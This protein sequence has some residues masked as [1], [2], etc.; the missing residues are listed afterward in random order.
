MDISKLRTRKEIPA[1]V[2]SLGL[3]DTWVEVGVQRGFYSRVLLEFC[4]ELK[5]LIL[6]DAWR[7]LGK[8]YRDTA[9]VSNAE[10]EKRLAICKRNLA[11]WD[12]A[13]KLEYLRMTS[14]DAAKTIEAESLDFVYLDADHSYRAVTD[15]IKAWFP[16]IKWGGVIAGHDYIDGQVNNSEFGVKRAVTEFAKSNRLEVYRTTQIE[17]FPSWII[18]KERRKCRRH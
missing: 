16:L 4:P 12:K 8:E 3:T 11:Y 9:N 10:H 6:V 18:R 15:D 7:N 1:Y 13:G 2:R 5:K 14:L 17:P